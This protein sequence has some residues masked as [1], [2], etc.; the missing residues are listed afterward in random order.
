M[1]IIAPKLGL[2]NF[3]F[4]LLSKNSKV[5]SLWMKLSERIV[6]YMYVIFHSLL[7]I[8]QSV[9]ALHVLKANECLIS[10]SILYWKAHTY[11]NLVNHILLIFTEAWSFLN[12]N[13]GGVDWGVATK[14]DRSWGDTE[15]NKCMASYMLGKNLPLSYNSTFHNVLELK[16][17]IFFILC[18]NKLYDQR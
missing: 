16:M 18:L 6:Y 5:V 17:L 9:S 1:Q 11:C 8:P 14:G 4:S 10:A 15:R 2:A 13:G 7:R 12:R 3:Y